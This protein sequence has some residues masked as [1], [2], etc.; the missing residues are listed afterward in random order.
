LE[1]PET[2]LNQLREVIQLHFATRRHSALL[3][4][5]IVGFAVRPM[6]GDSGDAEAVFGVALVLLL[7]IALY[8]VNLDELV[9]RRT[10]NGPG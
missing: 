8:N 7:L 2:Q 10:P 3:I 9:S 1:G 4:A 5:I 6:I